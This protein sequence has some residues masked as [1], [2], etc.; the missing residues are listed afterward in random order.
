MAGLVE[1]INQPFGQIAVGIDAPVAQEGPVRP[2]E[3]DFSQIDGHDQNFFL[4]DGGPGENFAGGAGHKTLPPEFESGTADAGNN[5]MADPI[6]GRNETAVGHGMGTLNGF[7]GAV[8]P[9]A[10]FLFLTGMPADG[11]GIE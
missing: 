9:F 7:P 5:L 10:V 11:G 1:L 4:I 8:L 6:H 2:G 3:V